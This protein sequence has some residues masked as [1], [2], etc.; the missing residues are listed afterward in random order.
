[1]PGQKWALT[2]RIVHLLVQ[3][4]GLEIGPPSTIEDMILSSLETEFVENA[5]RKEALD[6]AVIRAD[7]FAQTFYRRY[8]PCELSNLVQNLQVC[9]MF[10]EAADLSEQVTSSL[11]DE[12]ILAVMVTHLEIPVSPSGLPAKSHLEA[13]C[14]V[15]QTIGFTSGKLWPEAEETLLFVFRA[16]F[17]SLKPTRAIQFYLF[18]DALGYLCLLYRAQ[19][20]NLPNGGDATHINE[21]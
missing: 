11:A 3:L 21:V 8:L 9:S 5:W 6:V 20:S 13:R 15:Q 10:R 4:A 14:Y 7:D 16:L 2:F 19:L 1:M 18:R 12:T 17:T